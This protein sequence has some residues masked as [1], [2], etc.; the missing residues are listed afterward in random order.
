LGLARLT[1]VTVISPRSEYEQVAKAL[2]QFEDFHPIDGGVGKF[3]P[4]VEELAVK[5]VRLFAQADQA[6]KDLGLQPTPGWMD[7][8]FGGVKV[9]K[10][11]YEAAHWEEL[12]DRADRELDPI[13]QEVKTQKA[14]LQKAAKEESDARTAMDALHA[15]SSL[16]ADLTG[17]SSLNRVRAAV[18]IVRNSAVQ[19][20]RNSLPNPIF[21]AQQL[22]ETESLVLVAVPAADAQTLDRTMKALELRQLAIPPALPQNPSQAFKELEQEASAARDRRTEVESKLSEIK[23]RSGSRLLG[24]RELT[25]AARDMLDEARASGDLKRL[26][27]ISGYIPSKDEGR[28]TELF[29]RWMTFTEPAKVGE[30]EKL[31]VLFE[32]SRGASLW[33]PITKEQGIPG[34]HE[35]DPTPLISFV[36]PIFFGL[37]FGDFGH[38]LLLTLFVLFV[39]QRVS[40]SKRQWADIFLAFGISSMVFGVVFGEFFGFSLYSALPI[41]PI[42]SYL[43][44]DIINR[45]GASPVPDIANFEKLMIISIMIGT[46]HLTTG[47]S[48][49]VYEGVKAG[50]RMHV[51]LEKLPALT[52]YL[53]GIG[54]GV[55]FVVG[56]FSF[57]VLASTATVPS[58]GVQNSVL[59]AASLAILIPS[60][61]VL[62]LGKAV[63]VK[64]G[65]VKGISFAGAISG[66]GLEVFEKI[67]QFLSNTISYVR[68]AVM[69]LVHAVLLLIVIQFFPP[70]NLELAPA[71]VVFN[72]L[73][74]ALEGLIV[75][76]QDLRLHVYEFFTKFYTGTGAPFR[77]I[78]PARP[79]AGIKWV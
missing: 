31:P 56:G 60:M 27:T 12:L 48:L 49:D 72:L 25:E 16:S 44:I 15:V 43:N 71:W 6:A 64:M 37:M 61:L 55:A 10:S 75:Y 62:L 65:R 28:F 39:R 36:F 19:E 29:G 73:V 52:M 54:Y 26:A 14:A 51:L 20:F 66:G 45:S 69:L 22:N 57:N 33:E 4:K 76:V 18:C 38:G 5:A 58:L 34:K 1:K 59:G 79:R 13:A 24:V 8:V 70:S 21:Q 32:N 7:M 30:G 23:E 17:L 77:K 78:L 47:L 67:L 41:P 3:D 74:L 63:A 35:V 11:T 53:S 40:G 68:L 46:A 9:E 50:E 42:A 2:A